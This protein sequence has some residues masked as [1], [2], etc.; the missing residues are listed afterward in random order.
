MSKT[1][2]TDTVTYNLYSASEAAAFVARCEA[3]GLRASQERAIV[4]VSVATRH[5]R[6]KADDATQGKGDRCG[7]AFG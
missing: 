3:A 4:V 7:Y 6:N 1:P 2:R 5:D